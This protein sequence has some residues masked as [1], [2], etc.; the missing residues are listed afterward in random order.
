MQPDGGI[1]KRGCHTS[2]I[3][4]HAVEIP[5]RARSRISFALTVARRIASIVLSIH[6]PKEA[7]DPTQSNSRA[8]DRLDGRR[9]RAAGL[10]DEVNAM[11]IRRMHSVFLLVLG[12]A[13]VVPVVSAR[14]EEGPALDVWRP[15]G[16]DPEKYVMGIDSTVTRTGKGAGFIRSKEGTTAGWS[17]WMQSFEAKPYLG[18]ALRFSAYV[19]T[20]GVDQQAVLWMRV[21]GESGTLAF[22]NMR[23]RPIRGTTAWTEHAIVLDVSPDSKAIALGVMLYGAGAVWIDDCALTD[24]PLEPPLPISGRIL[25]KVEDEAGRPLE[26]ALVAV[27]APGLPDPVAIVHSGGDG[28]FHLVGIPAGRYGMTATLPGREAAYVDSVSVD[29]GGTTEAVDMTLRPGGVTFRGDV[30]GPDRTPLSGVLVEALRF[31]NMQGDVFCCRADENGRYTITLPAGYQYILTVQSDDV[32]LRQHVN[33]E[34]DQIVDLAATSIAEDP[35]PGAVIAWLREAAIPLQSVE[36]EHGFADMEPLRRMVGDAHLVCLGEATH[37]TREFFQLKHRMLELL[38]TRMG[39]SVFGIEATFPESFDVNRYVLTGEGD[40]AQALAN[41]HFWTWNTEE[42]LGMIRWMR[43]YNQNASNPRKLKFYGFD[44]QFPGDAA[45]VAMEYLLRVDPTSADSVLADL[46]RFRTD[47]G[48][49]A[50]LPAEERAAIQ[51]T[52]QRVLAIFDGKKE[53]YVR[54]SSAEEWGIARQHARVVQQ[55]GESTGSSAASSPG[56]RDRFMAENVQ[57]ILQHEGPGTRMVVWA[58]NGHISTGEDQLGGSRPMGS[59]L[60]GALGPDMVT[61]GFAFDQGSFRAVDGG[62]K[63]N[64]VQ[65][66]SVGPAL[67]GSLDQTLA[68][69]NMPIAVVDLRGVPDSGIVSDWFARPHRMKSIGAVYSL[70]SGRDYYAK[71]RVTGDFDALFFVEETSAALPVSGPNRNKKYRAY[72]ENLDFESAGR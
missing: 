52:L 51:A 53:E 34:R 70:A 60:R 27:V 69:L 55:Y 2:A 16:A 31:S 56:L 41:L 21:D 54:N 11:A 62:S 37:G 64:V 39:F 26:G 25:G 19:K 3:R 29:G 10:A 1:M 61:F 38:A 8:R 58:H 14:G 48:Q 66:F 24:A 28:R 72:P 71:V 44:M 35:A 30:L 5:R 33:A 65:P 57:W 50:R 32:E 67:E 42:V 17:T 40:P 23:D 12:L 63:Q 18:K 46:Q 36:A 13:F 45:K 7:C 49:L 9:R 15:A 68:R 59:W 4:E 22:D 6:R 43:E 47:P 20:E